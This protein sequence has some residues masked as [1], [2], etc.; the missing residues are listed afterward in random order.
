MNSLP[1]V[2]GFFSLLFFLGCLAIGPQLQAFTFQTLPE[3]L[4]GGEGF[5]LR[6]KGNPADNYQALF[7]RKKYKPFPASKGVWEIFLPLSIK[8]AGERE[9]ILEKISPDAPTEK[10]SFLV[11]VTQKKI[12][13]IFLGKASRKMR[14]EEP[15]ISKQQKKVLAAINNR[16]PRKYWNQPF[17][18]P[19]QGEIGTEFG[20]KRNL[21]TYSSYH[22]GVDI[23]APE[24][25]PVQAANRGKVILSEHNFN[26]YGN[27]LIIDHGQGVVSCYF[28]LSQIF[29]ET[30]DMVDQNE[31]IAEVGNT[32]WSD[33]AH[34]H[35]SVYLQ[36][37]PVDP[38]WWVSFTPE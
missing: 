12:R 17:S 1:F 23:S 7:E 35:F 28:H 9:L 29:K 20:I 14:K 22:W 6:L 4:T 37:K 31:I 36:G 8:A 13:T 2:R 33:G 34:L 21:G 38:L 3:N 19:L 15:S 32:G 26:I 24:G 11:N 10:Y 25:T 27:L 5:L 30:G 18:L 16:E